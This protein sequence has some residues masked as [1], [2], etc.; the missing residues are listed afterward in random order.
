[1]AIDD[2]EIEHR[3]AIPRSLTEDMVSDVYKIHLNEEVLDLSNEFCKYYYATNLE[4]EDEYFALVFSNDFLQDYHRLAF[5]SKNHIPTLNQVISYSI[6]YIS[7]TKS[8]QLVA[9]VDK[10]DNSDNLAQYIANNHSLSTKEIEGIIENIAHTMINLESAGIY[11]CNINPENI[12]MQNGQFLAIREFINSYPHFHQKNQ[13]LAPEIVECEKAGRLVLTAKADIYAVGVTIFEAFSHKSIWNDHKSNDDY[14]YSR[15]ENTTYKYLL[16][17]IRLQEKL[18][19]FFKYTLHDEANIRWS[20]EQLLEWLAGKIT[21]ASHDSIA[22]NKNTI[23]FGETNHSSRKSLAYGLFKN[24]NEATRFI[25]D[26]KLFKWVSRENISADTLEEIKAIVEKKAESPF[27]TTNTSGS[28]SKVSKILSLLDQNGPIRLEDIAFSAPSIPILVHYLITH[29]RRDAVEKII[30]LIKEEAWALYS[31]NHDAAGYLK[32]SLADHYMKIASYV[33]FSSITKGLD[34]FNYSLNNKLHCYSTLFKNKHVSTLHEL[35]DAM[36]SIAAKFP[37]RLN[38]DKNVI[39]FVSA[40]LDI[41]D[42]IKPAILQNFPKFSEHHSVRNLSILYILEKNV[43]GMKIPLT[44]TVIANQLK[45]MFEES[46][47]N[48]EFRQKLSDQLAQVAK[49]ESIKNIVQLLYDQQPFVNDYNGYYEA[50][51]K[52]KMIEQQIKALHNEDSVFSTALLL[53]QKMTV[54]ISYVLCFI[55]TIAVLL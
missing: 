5:L 29:N 21:K 10:Y 47:H 50:C 51:K 6:V 30:K 18:R 24:W 27:V 32:N 53:G 2:K 41:L 37:T 49:E 43:K 13:Y 52:T 3:D 19:I 31:K 11:G 15:F 12:L 34:R 33:Q 4:T 28:Q 35:I 38:I 9:I 40:K 44:V 55:V 45:E 20:P 48:I 22:D 16:T 23:A 26:A 17:G 39:A 54:L 42:E 1:M 7:S 36:E 46:I 8:E 25:K 14:N